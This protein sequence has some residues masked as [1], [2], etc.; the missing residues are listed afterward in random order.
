MIRYSC[1]ALLLIGCQQGA[2]QPEDV[3]SYQDRSSVA[4]CPC[5]ERGQCRC[6]DVLEDV[7]YRAITVTF[8]GYVKIGNGC[9]VGEGWTRI[10]GGCTTDNI[11]QCGAPTIETSLPSG[12]QGWR[13]EAR[14]ECLGIARVTAV[15]ARC[16]AW[17]CE[18]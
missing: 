16:K 7:E 12:D 1:L 10:D 14:G 4:P 8:D 17:R 5:P 9:D 6:D 11:D 2:A 15:C 3:A 13:C 18:Q